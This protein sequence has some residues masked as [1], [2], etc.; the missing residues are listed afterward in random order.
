MYQRIGAEVE[1]LGIDQR[2][3]SRFA[4]AEKRES[5]TDGLEG[6]HRSRCFSS[7]ED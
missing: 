6:Q 7:R 5:E 3:V 1:I 4:E 2:E